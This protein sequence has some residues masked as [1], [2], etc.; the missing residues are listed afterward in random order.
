EAVATPHSGHEVA[1]L[2]RACDRVGLPVTFRSGGSSLSGQAGTEHLLVDTRRAFRSV[3]VLDDGRR[4][5][6]QPGTTLAVVNA[7][8]APYGTRL[9]PDP[10]SETACTIG[11]L[12]TNNSSGMT[13]GTEFNTYRTL[14]SAKLVLPSGTVLDTAHDD[15]D[16]QL[17]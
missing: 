4:V 5:R 6:A 8:L 3:T 1:A 11:G 13:C 15:A 9:G 16:A 12:V 14:E 10:A 2:L 17:R 7:H